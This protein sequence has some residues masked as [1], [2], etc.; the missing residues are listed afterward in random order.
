[1]FS[2]VYDHLRLRIAFVSWLPYPNSFIFA[3]GADPRLTESAM[4]L[5]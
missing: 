5:Q 4:Y 1:M 2:L 3:E